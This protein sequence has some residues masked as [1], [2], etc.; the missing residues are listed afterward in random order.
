MTSRVV[1]IRR[2]VLR[3][4]PQQTTIGAWTNQW[5]SVDPRPVA[6]TRA[7]AERVDRQRGAGEGTSGARLHQLPRSNPSL[8]LRHGSEVTRASNQIVFA[9]SVAPQNWW[10]RGAAP[11]K[12]NHAHGRREGRRWTPQLRAEVA[13]TDLHRPNGVASLCWAG[14]EGTGRPSRGYPSTLRKGRQPR[15]WPRAVMLGQVRGW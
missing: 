4:A 13:A 15:W 2:V 5:R 14:R 12:V 3:D 10:C 6:P 8:L 7:C 1:R 11:Q 9:S